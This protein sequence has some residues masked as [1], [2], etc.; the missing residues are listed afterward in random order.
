MTI[1]QDRARRQANAAKQAR[2]RHRAL[3]DPDGL[4][5]TRVQA[6]IGPRAAADLRRIKKRTGW[7]QQ[8]IFERAI[9]LLYDEART[10]K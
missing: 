5:L 10:E 8:E 7:T 6:L 4:L 9:A 2:Y 1:K 3:H